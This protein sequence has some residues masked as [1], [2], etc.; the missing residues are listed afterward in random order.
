MFANNAAG[1]SINPVMTYL[2]IP[3]S[4]PGPPVIE[5]YLAYNNKVVLTFSGTTGFRPIL[6]V[7]Y[8]INGSSFQYNVIPVNNTVEIVSLANGKIYA[9][10]II[11][12]NIAG[13]SHPSDYFN[14]YT[15]PNPPVIRTIR[16]GALSLIVDIIQ[17][18]DE[19]N[20]VTKY[21]YTY[22]NRST[23]QSNTSEIALAEL[24]NPN[25]FT[26]PGL[27]YNAI[28]D[29][30]VRSINYYSG[31]SEP[32][33]TVSGI[34]ADVPEPP[35]IT[36]YDKGNEQV[37]VYFELG[38]SRGYPITE[39]TYVLYDYYPDTGITII[40]ET[41]LD[42]IDSPFVIADLVNG[43]TYQIALKAKNAVGYSALSN[44]IVA[45]PFTRPSPPIITNIT[46][47]NNTAVIDFAYGENG[48][49]DIIGV[50][51]EIFINVRNLIYS[52][53]VFTTPTLVSTPSLP[54]NVFQ[55]RLSG[56]INQN[57]YFIRL[58]AINIAGTSNEYYEEF[59]PVTS[60]SALPLDH[61]RSTLNTNASSLSKKQQYALMVR[62]SKGNTRF[63]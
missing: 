31:K 36:N 63:L 21:E 22:T 46:A 6:S 20:T 13:D 26:I 62:V 56:L 19:I 34:P 47:I 14:I 28:Y 12:V 29:V 49:S 3:Y 17:G 8:S 23:N 11:T 4:V 50:R 25:E 1:L 18:E 15:I 37:T 38:D 60:E 44:K 45:T 43:F 52:N 2:L 35:V 9:L 41:I 7:K 54:A 59:I 5:S 61:R 48:G 30:Y 24:T 32:S 53:I 16:P 51:A 27:I 33:D 42:T 40:T 39:C 10:R 57:K 58:Y 55:I